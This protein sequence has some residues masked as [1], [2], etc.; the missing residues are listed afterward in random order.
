TQAI[1]KNITETVFATGTL[2][3]EDTYQLMA[4]T[5]GYLVALHFEEG[6]VVSKNE[7]LVEIDNQESRVNLNGNAE[8]YEI[9]KRNAQSDAPAFQQVEAN[10]AMIRQRLVQDSLQAA[11]YQR[12]WEQ[13]S[14]AK[15]EYETK[16]LAYQN[17]QKELA[18]TWENYKKLRRDAEQQVVVAQT[19][20]RLSN[21]SVGKV[22]LKAFAGGKVYQKHKEV[23]DFVRKGEI[24]ATIGHPDNI[25]ARINVDESSIAKISVGQKAVIQLN[26]NLSENL[27]AKVREILPTFDQASQSFI[28]ELTFVDPLSFKIIN[29]Q[30]QC[31]I[32]IG[33]EEEVLLV[34]RK[35]V[36][37]NNQV[38]VKGEDQKRKIETKI[39]SNEWVQVLAGIE[40]SDVLVTTVN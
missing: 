9:A 16:L 28:C 6:D 4:E 25:Y 26:T 11:R 8:L 7:V 21:L 40:Q 29:T 31:N 33:K 30:L 27:E 13:N 12:L 32:V 22:R 1:R 34:P 19:N 2:Q 35:Y 5:E 18:A 39:V 36:D 37:F 38:Q 10:M 23:G 20:K 17:T 15:V 3:A 14:I 24:I